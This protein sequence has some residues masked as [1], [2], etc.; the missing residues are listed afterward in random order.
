MT[1][2]SSAGLRWTHLIPKA[3]ILYTGAELNL[4][5]RVIEGKAGSE[6]E[7]FGDGH[8]GLCLLKVLCPNLEDSGKYYHNCSKRM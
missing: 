8:S 4:R 3:N 5:S 2:G 6:R 1:S 7:W